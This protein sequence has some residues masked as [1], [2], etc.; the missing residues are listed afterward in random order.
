MAVDGPTRP[1]INH[2]EIHIDFMIG[3]DDVDVTGITRAGE[4]R[5]PLLRGGN[6]QI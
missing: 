5:V 4:E 1:R 2:S 6:W 3:D